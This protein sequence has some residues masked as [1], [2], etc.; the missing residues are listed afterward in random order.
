MGPRN[1]QPSAPRQIP[2]Y[3]YLGPAVPV[4]KFPDLNFAFRP[5]LLT[6]AQI[7]G[8]LQ[9]YPKRMAQYFELLD[10]PSAEEE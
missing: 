10:P 4:M 1:K 8:I 7:F 9:R 5:P 6:D 3:R 2:L